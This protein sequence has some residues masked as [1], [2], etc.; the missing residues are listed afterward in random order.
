MCL[1]PP[2]LVLVSWM[3]LSAATTLA[4]EP[5]QTVT[6]HATDPLGDPLPPFAR[7]RLGTDRFRHGAT[8]HTLA[9]S[10]N[11]KVIASIGTDS[12]VRLWDFATGKELRALPMSAMNGAVSIDFSPDGKLLTMACG[13]PRLFL[14]QLDSGQEL[15]RFEGGQFGVSTVHFFPDGKTIATT[16][17]PGV[18]LWDVASG[19]LTG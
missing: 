8:V 14:W 10:P 7:A 19:K 9:F 16:G 3:T 6:S 17:G 12:R 18:A 1:R 11:G 4:A 13:W 15:R 2:C 5:P